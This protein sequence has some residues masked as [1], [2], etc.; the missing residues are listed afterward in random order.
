MMI[1]M[2]NRDKTQKFR[3]LFKGKLHL[4]IVVLSCFLNQKV[5]I[6]IKLLRLSKRLPNKM[7]LLQSF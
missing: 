1:D 5:M 6:N 4:Q 2:L 7:R 3:F